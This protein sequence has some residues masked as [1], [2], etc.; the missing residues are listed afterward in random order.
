MRSRVL[1]LF[2]VLVL[3]LGAVT[4]SASAGVFTAEGSF[5][6]TLKVTGPV[7]LDI[8]TGSGSITVRPGE[9]GSVHII[10]TI[11]ARSDWGLNMR[12]AEEKVR[13]LEANP[14]IVQT[15]TMIRLGYIEDREL[16]RNVSI[17]YEVTVPRETKLVSHTGSGSQTVDG[18][19]GPVYAETGSGSLT[20]TSIGSEVE[21]DT[22]SG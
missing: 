10:G 7:D 11:K 19:Q 3:A 12:E 20:I 2:A 15:G 13:Q 16:R 17:S 18:I 4:L 9:G 8:E 6:R 14:P 22:G 5:D 21:A 1:S